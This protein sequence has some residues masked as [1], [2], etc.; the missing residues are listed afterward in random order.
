[1]FLFALLR[2]DRYLTNDT[3]R[4]F[5]LTINNYVQLRRATIDRIDIPEFLRHEFAYRQ[6]WFNLGTPA[7]R[8]FFSIIG[9]I[10]IV[11]AWRWDTRG[12]FSRIRVRFCFASLLHH[13]KLVRFKER[14]K[15]RRRRREIGVVEGR[16]VNQYE[17]I[18]SIW[19][20][21]WSL[22]RE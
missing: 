12:E 18:E 15:E 9:T 2:D 14:E 11:I 7:A 6:T 8:C 19:V 16:T 20:F 3:H 4:E 5:G 22:A 1:M 10:I 17:I 13:E 21:K